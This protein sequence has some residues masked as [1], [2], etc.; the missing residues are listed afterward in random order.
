MSET[1]ENILEDTW[2]QSP[3]CEDFLHTV[4][5]RCK[6]AGITVHTDTIADAWIQGIGT[7]P[8]FKER[9]G[10]GFLIPIGDDDE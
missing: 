4:M 3:S 1:L 9:F 2:L 10:G 5:Q 8:T 7:P 6:E